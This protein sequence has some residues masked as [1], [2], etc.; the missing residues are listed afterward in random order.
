MIGTKNVMLSIIF[1]N[2]IHWAQTLILKGLAYVDLTIFGRNMPTKK[3]HLHNQEQT[4]PFG[5]I[6]RENMY[7]FF[8]K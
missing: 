4:A 7:L 8:K 1:I 3:E 5:T 6:Y 2:F